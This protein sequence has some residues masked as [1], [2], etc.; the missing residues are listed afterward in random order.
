MT[1]IK[2]F[3]RSF[4]AVFIVMFGSY[5]TGFYL[6]NEISFTSIFCGILGFFI[7]F[8]A[9]KKWDQML[10]GSDANKD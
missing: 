5:L 3:L 10:G 6:R 7:L 8:P 2:S 4:V 1:R 9:I